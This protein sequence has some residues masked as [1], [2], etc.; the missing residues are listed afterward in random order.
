MAPRGTASR[1]ALRMAALVVAVAVLSGLFLEVAT[2]V[3]SPASGPGHPPAPARSSTRLAAVSRD[4]VR[5]SLSVPWLASTV[6]VNSTEGATPA[7]V[8]APAGPSRAAAVVQ[9]PRPAP[10]TEQQTT[11]PAAPAEDRGRPTPAQWARLRDCES[12]GDYAADTHN[13]YFGAYQANL[14]T[15]ESN[16]FAGN[17]AAAT[18]ATQDAFAVLLYARRG[19]QPWPVCGKWLR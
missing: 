19:P 8:I 5:A 18:P 14:L 9:L 2:P 13:G 1:V 17:P 12:S 11:I 7:G 16:G 6:S 4:L 15:W 10:A 3:S